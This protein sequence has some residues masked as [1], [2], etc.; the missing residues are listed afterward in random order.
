MVY[1]NGTCIDFCYV[2]VL[3][4]ALEARSCDNSPSTPPYS[5]SAKP[6]SEYACGEEL[7][8]A[9]HIVLV[10]FDKSLLFVPERKSRTCIRHHGQ[11]LCRKERRD[12]CWSCN[13]LNA[14]YAT[15]CKASNNFPWR[16]E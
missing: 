4:R 9:T 10:I 12:S 13:W 7:K 8:F 6:A 11:I 5:T 16:F 2:L 15:P 1:T 14:Q 3:L